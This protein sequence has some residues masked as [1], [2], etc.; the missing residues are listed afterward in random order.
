MGIWG[1]Y[2]NVVINMADIQDETYKKETINRAKGLKDRAA[3][4]S[5]QILEI[6]EN[7]SA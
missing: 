1:A 5:G 2:K 7:R 3:K 4:M 6:L